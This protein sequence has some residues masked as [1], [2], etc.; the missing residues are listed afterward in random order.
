MRKDIYKDFDLPTK[1]LSGAT[2]YIPPRTRDEEEAW[3][4]HNNPEGTLVLE[5]QRDG[6]AMARTIL[7]ASKELPEKDI[8]FVSDMIAA[9]G[10][11]S[12]WYSFAR[13]ASVQRRRL[14][15]EMLATDDPEQ[16]PTTYML[17]DNAISDLDQTYNE[18]GL[19]VAQ[20]MIHDPEIERQHKIVGRSIGHAA[21]T[22][23]CAPLGDKIGYGE[24]QMTDFELQE[25]ARNQGLETLYRARLLDQELG[26][27]PSIAQL[28]DPDS[29][30]CV[31]WRR[32]APNGAMDAY[33][34][35]L[36]EVSLN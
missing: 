19:L 27:A 13:S 31:Y 17:I 10:L 9:S 16:R 34:Y 35:A 32:N 28:P 3:R 6:I 2:D 7:S 25:L 23:S 15:L 5:K 33:E 26:R 1:H 4:R 12:A 14:K 36:S 20:H 11:N 30:F 22:L 24:I 18:S 21:L 8:E 29:E